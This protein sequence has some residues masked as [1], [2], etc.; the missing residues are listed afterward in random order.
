MDV[1]SLN[2]TEQP[3][4]AFLANDNSNNVFLWHN[5]VQYATGTLKRLK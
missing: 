3:L 5:G 1:V 4:T 2:G